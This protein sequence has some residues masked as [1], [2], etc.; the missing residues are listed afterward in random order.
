ME[1]NIL[2]FLF[3]IMTSI[4]HIHMVPNPTN[5]VLTPDHFQDKI[6]AIVSIIFM[7]NGITIEQWHF[8]CWVLT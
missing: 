3:S 5:S 6:E 8:F 2:Y 4:I 1:I 7:T